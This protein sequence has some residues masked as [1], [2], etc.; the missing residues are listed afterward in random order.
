MS[1][2][3]DIDKWERFFKTALA[4][5]DL[6]KELLNKL[7]KELAKK[8]F[9]SEIKTYND[10]TTYDFTNAILSTNLKIGSLFAYHVSEIIKQ[11]IDIYRPTDKYIVSFSKANNSMLMWSH[12]ASKHKGFCLVFKSINGCLYQNKRKIKRGIGRN[13]PNGIIA[14][15]ASFGINE[16]FQFVDINY[17][18]ECT[19]IDAAMYMP[20]P[21]FGRNPQ[22]EEERLAF[23]N[24][25]Y[26][27]S[28]EKHKCW[29]YEQEARLVLDTPMPWIF[30]E[31][32]KYTQD[33]RLFYYQPTQLVGII[34]GAWMDEHIKTRIKEIINYHREQMWY[35]IKDDTVFDFVLF[36]AKISNE[37]RS[38]K[39]VPELIYTATEILQIDNPK[40]TSCY[41]AW[42]KG[43]AIVF[44]GQGGTKKEYIQ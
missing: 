29:E 9:A 14:K 6:P 39:V 37:N 33:E 22:N 12:Y 40:F 2:E 5:T 27:K 32:F 20:S 21:V 36:Q 17:C 24:E 25:S 44:N 34:C 8:I 35:N 3:F 10:I 30:G 18:S 42:E 11:F 16:K 1:Y 15:H 28:F 31:H 4:K 26:R 23:S 7:S 43:E 19:M 38:I 41:Q 13:T